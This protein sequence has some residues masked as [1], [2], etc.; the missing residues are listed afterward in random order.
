MKRLLERYVEVILNRMF[1]YGMGDMDEQEKERW[2]GYAY[3]VALKMN[4][5]NDES[6]N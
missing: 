5:E 6:N 2:N 1:P 3:D 4:E